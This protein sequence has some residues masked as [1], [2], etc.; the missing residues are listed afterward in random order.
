MKYNIRW[1]DSTKTGKIVVRKY[2]GNAVQDA[3]SFTFTY[4]GK[5]K[6]IS[7]NDC[8]AYVLINGIWQAA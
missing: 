2:E 3:N 7:K 5:E 1:F 8:F 6:T 4:N